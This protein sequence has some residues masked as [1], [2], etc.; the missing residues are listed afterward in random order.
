MKPLQ[1]PGEADFVFFSVFFSPSWGPQEFLPQRV[2]PLKGLKDLGEADFVFFSVFFSPS[3]GPQGFFFY[4]GPCG[5]L[6]RPHTPRLTGAEPL[7]GQ[8][9]TFVRAHARAQ[10]R[11]Q[12]RAARRADR[13][14]VL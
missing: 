8:R 7:H 2:K 3:W 13:T 4:E 5:D 1:A 11:P 6:K 14:L 12:A 10:A 9:A